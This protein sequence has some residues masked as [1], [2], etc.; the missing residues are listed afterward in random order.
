M[1]C[2]MALAATLLA[3]SA[4][5]CLFRAVWARRAQGLRLAD[6]KAWDSQDQSN[7]DTRLMLM[8]ISAFIDSSLRPPKD[9]SSKRADQ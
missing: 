7:G 2:W 9:S 6:G 8:S 5:I 1:P 4:T 3:A